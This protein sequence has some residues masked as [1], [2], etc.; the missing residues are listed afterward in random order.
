MADRLGYMHNRV[1][2]APEAFI[3]RHKRSF[4]PRRKRSLKPQKLETIIE[5]GPEQTVNSASFKIAMCVFP[6]FLYYISYTLANRS[7]VA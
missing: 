7:S 2:V 5:E 4:V 3:Y 6:V 1:E